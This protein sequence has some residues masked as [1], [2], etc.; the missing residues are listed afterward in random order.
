MEGLSALLVFSTVFFKLCVFFFLSGPVVR[1]NAEASQREVKRPRDGTMCSQLVV[2]SCTTCHTFSKFSMSRTEEFC[3]FQFRLSLG[4]FAQF[5]S[6]GALICR[7]C[8]KIR[9]PHLTTFCFVTHGF[10]DLIAV[11]RKEKSESSLHCTHFTHTHH[12]P[13]SGRFGHPHLLHDLHFLCRDP[14]TLIV[15]RR[16]FPDRFNPLC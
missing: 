8:L 3:P 7:F 5:A 16:K 6:V 15:L 11:D 4:Q 14:Q 12:R 2:S 13:H 10:T 9:D 1:A